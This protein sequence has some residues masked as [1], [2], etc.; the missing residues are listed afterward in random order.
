M[1]VEDKPQNGIQHK[2]VLG[3][4]IPVFEQMLTS[5]SHLGVS[6]GSQGCPWPLVDLNSNCQVNTF[7]S[8]T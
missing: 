2:I 8:S 1:S 4:L 3:S 7:N 6:H 5:L